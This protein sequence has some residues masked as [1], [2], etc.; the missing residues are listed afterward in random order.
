MNMMA[1]RCGEDIIVIDAGLMF[2]EQELLGVDIVIPDITYLKQKKHKGRASVLTH[3]QEDHIGGIPSI[4][5]ELN[6]PVYGTEFTL[7]IVKKK[8]E[9]PGLLEKATL[10]EVK[11][12]DTTVLGPFSIEYLH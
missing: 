5:P 8:L 9:E 10:N 3:A 11:A 2:P 1:L 6:V 7:A 4:I 12:G